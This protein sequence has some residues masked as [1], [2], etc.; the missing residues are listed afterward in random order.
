MLFCGRSFFQGGPASAG[1]RSI[2]GADYRTSVEP[3]ARRAR[4]GAE[5]AVHGAV[6]SCRKDCDL[7]VEIVILRHE[8]SVL[9]RQVKMTVLLGFT[10]AAY[11]LDRVRSFRAKQAQDKENPRRR[12]KRRQGTWSDVV[13]APRS[14]SSER[15][16]GPPD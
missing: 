14:L 12:A 2:A 10:L 11:N 8:V 9:R 13:T 16:T 5:N 4:V 15:S 3:W 1:D 7:A 6:H